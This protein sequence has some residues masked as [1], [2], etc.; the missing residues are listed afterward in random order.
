[1]KTSAALACTAAALLMAGAAGAGPEEDRLAFVAWFEARFPDVE[2]A[3]FANGIYAIDADSRQQWLEIEE[4][5]PYEFSVESG[6]T[7]WNEP[8]PGGDRWIWGSAR[9][10]T[11]PI[12]IR[13]SRS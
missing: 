5:P 10:C 8:L 11:R 4:F 2:F 12:S 13:R 7:A 9:R 6:E 1:M 3:E